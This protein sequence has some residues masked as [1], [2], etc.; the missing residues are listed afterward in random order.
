VLQLPVIIAE[1][2][3]EVSDEGTYDDEKFTH[4]QIMKKSSDPAVKVEQSTVNYK[5]ISIII[6]YCNVLKS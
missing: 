2:S 1:V 5:G 3:A 4:G 6:L